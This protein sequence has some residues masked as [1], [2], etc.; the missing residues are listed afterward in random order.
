VTLKIFC[1]LKQIK[2]CIH[3]EKL[4]NYIKKLIDSMKVGMKKKRH[5]KVAGFPPKV[6]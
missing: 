3:E 4:L 2:D 5:N 6:A 1:L